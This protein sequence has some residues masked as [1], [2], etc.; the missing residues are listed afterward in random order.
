MSNTVVTSNLPCPFCRENELL[1]GVV[2]YEDDLWYYVEFN[3]KE[4]KNSGMVITKR[5]IVTPFEISVEEWTQLHSLLPKLKQ[6]I[7]DYSPDGYNIGWNVGSA[8][9]QNVMHAHMH[10]LPRY[11]DEPLA[12]KG[13][14]YAFKQYENKRPAR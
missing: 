8:A 13:I 10:I 14:R 6:L 5:H 3:D 1:K 7:D 9:G 2:R 11:A 4:I 12:G